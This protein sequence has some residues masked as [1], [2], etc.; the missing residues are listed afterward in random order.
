MWV[1]ESSELAPDSWLPFSYLT[2]T[3]RFQKRSFR[4]A[5]CWS[6]RPPF[7]RRFTMRNAWPLAHPNIEPVFRATVFR[8]AESDSQTGKR[9]NSSKKTAAKKVFHKSTTLPS[10]GA[11]MRISC[12]HVRV[13]LEYSDIV[14]LRILDFPE[15]NARFEANACRSTPTRNFICRARMSRQTWG[16]WPDARSLSPETRS[17]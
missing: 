6:V 12:E 3:F 8:R 11:K 7:A 10:V 4:K 1:Q 9:S 5:R 17:P 14:K 2:A 16:L 13:M 15:G